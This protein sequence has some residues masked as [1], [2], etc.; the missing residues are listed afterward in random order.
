MRLAGDAGRHGAAEIQGLGLGV[1]VSEE[2]GGLSRKERS[3]G[4][5]GLPKAEAVGVRVDLEAVAVREA[6]GVR[7]VALD[8]GLELAVGRGRTRLDVE[9]RLRSRHLRGA[10]DVMP[11][12]GASGGAYVARIPIAARMDTTAVQGGSD[13]TGSAVDALL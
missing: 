7:E 5:V 12:V 4:A 11:R 2:R 3:Q 6:V 10:V 13:R 9:P 8:E 1:G